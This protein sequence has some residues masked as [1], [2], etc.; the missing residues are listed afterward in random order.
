[1][2]IPVPSFAQ[3][4]RTHSGMEASFLAILPNYGCGSGVCIELG[5][6]VDMRA[7]SAE[8]EKPPPERGV[9]CGLRPSPSSRAPAKLGWYDG[10]RAGARAALSGA[11][12]DAAYQCTAS[13]DLGA[14]LCRSSTTRN[15]R[16]HGA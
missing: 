5:D 13:P 6:H 2:A 9:S 16:F 7:Q 4:I 10:P 12:L 8:K 14:F 3:G 1:M 11:K 15:I